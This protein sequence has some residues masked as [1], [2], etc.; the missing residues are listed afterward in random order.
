[1]LP[2]EERKYSKSG[3]QSFRGTFIKS[4]R[5]L[6]NVRDVYCSL[7]VLSM[8]SSSNLLKKGVSYDMLIEVNEGDSYE[9]FIKHEMIIMSCGI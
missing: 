9:N 6:L 3:V 2:S 4:L 7:R 8:I 1:M 5:S